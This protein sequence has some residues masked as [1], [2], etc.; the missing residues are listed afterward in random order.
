VATHAHRGSVTKWVATSRR[1]R[2]LPNTFP[3]SRHPHTVD[4]LFT[5]PDISNSIEIRVAN[6]GSQVRLIGKW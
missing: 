1:V 3:R 4:A 2:M 6:I 5:G